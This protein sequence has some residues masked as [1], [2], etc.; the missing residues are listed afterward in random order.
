MPW[1]RVPWRGEC[2]R[3]NRNCRRRSRCRRIRASGR[4]LAGWHPQRRREPSARWRE[5]SRVSLRSRREKTN[6]WSPRLSCF[7]ESALR[8]RQRIDA[9]FFAGGAPCWR[10][11]CQDRSCR[12]AF[13][14]SIAKVK[15]L[16]AGLITSHFISL[17]SCLLLES[18]ARPRFP[19]I[20]QSLLYRFAELGQICFYVFSDVRA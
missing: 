20:S 11:S 6:P 4:G 15:S 9:C 19:K 18:T 7:T 1:R 10:P 12:A 16:L 14:C 3:C 17:C 8:R 2:R 5:A 13:V